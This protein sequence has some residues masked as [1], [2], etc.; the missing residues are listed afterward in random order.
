MNK[1]IKTNFATKHQIIRDQTKKLKHEIKA[2]FIVCNDPIVKKIII[3]CTFV[4][5]ML[6]TKFYIL[7]FFIS[8]QSFFTY[9]IQNDGTAYFIDPVFCEG[10]DFFVHLFIRT[11]LGQ[12]IFSLE[13]FYLFLRSSLTKFGHNL[14]SLLRNTS[15]QE[16]I[17]GTEN[18]SPIHTLF[19]R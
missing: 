12:G 2:G 4:F 7:Y 14:L 13:I 5:S 15:S 17:K 18:A 1:K 11:N 6:E 9:F 16:R 8:V 19:H 10:T 3:I